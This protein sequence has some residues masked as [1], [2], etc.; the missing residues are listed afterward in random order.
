MITLVQIVKAAC[1]HLSEE[2]IIE[3]DKRI[4]ARNVQRRKYSTTVPTNKRSY[5]AKRC[6]LTELADKYPDKIA[7]AEMVHLLH[8]TSNTIRITIR[9]AGITPEIIQLGRKT[10]TITRDE[11]KRVFKK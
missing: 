10:F 1:P 5:S 9:K 2:E 4:L 11:F 3:R 7:M 8:R 6:N